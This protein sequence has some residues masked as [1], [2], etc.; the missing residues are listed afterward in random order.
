MRHHPLH[1]SE[2][3]ESVLAGAQVLRHI[4]E[5]VAVFA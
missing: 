2:H 3:D 5:F 1:F 4:A